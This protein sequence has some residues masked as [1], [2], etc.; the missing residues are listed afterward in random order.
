MA[1]QWV[2]EVKALG[3]LASVRKIFADAAPFEPSAELLAWHDAMVLYRGNRSVLRGADRV[4]AQQEFNRM[5]RDLFIGLQQKWLEAAL[6]LGSGSREKWVLFLQNVWVV[7]AGAV[8]DPF[9]IHLH[10][11]EIRRLRGATYPDFCK[12]LSRSPAMV[13]YLDLASNRAG[14]P[15]EN[16]ARELFELFILGEGKYG[17]NDIREAA[18]A[19]TGRTVRGGETIERPRLHDDGR[20]VVFGRS[21]RFSG[22]DIIDLAFRQP[23]A[24]TFLPS[25]LA[26][27]Y[28]GHEPLPQEYLEPLGR[29]W[30]ASGFSLSRLAEVFFCSRIF[31]HESFRGMRIKSPVELV[32]G[33][34]QDLD[35]PVPPVPQWTL[36]P[37]RIMGQELF[38]PPNVGGWPGGRAWIHSSAWTARH[39]W[40]QRLMSDPAR[41]SLNA[42]VERALR[43]F[44]EPVSLHPARIEDWWQGPREPASAVV[45]DLCERLLVRPVEEKLEKVLVDVF[46]S[47][48]G[49]FRR[50]LWETLH[51][52]LRVPEYQVC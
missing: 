31:F 44:G 42:D 16:F 1:P 38:N 5:R 17:E 20:K 25:E 7:Q 40:L 49:A 39:Q 15:N 34:L 28:L 45:A 4:S 41:Q 43:E 11:D 3:P 30:R 8:N 46:D 19:F 12:A 50:K 52:L 35:L 24:A 33:S 37:L 18:R 32:I 14:A 48:P 36:R 13:R 47:T 27:H 22:D 9:L 21:G 2:E 29:M 51:F 10:Q 23:S 26:R 6:S